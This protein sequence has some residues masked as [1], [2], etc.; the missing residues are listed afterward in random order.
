[1]KIIDKNKDYYDYLQ[2][3]WGQDPD[4][5]YAR[6]GS[7][8]FRPQDRPPFLSKDLP[9]GILCWQGEFIITCGAMVH[10]IYFE[11]RGKGLVLEEF[12]TYRV[13]RPE[14][15]AP[16]V[17]EW[18]VDEFETPGRK[19]YTASPWSKEGYCYICRGRVEGYPTKRGTRNPPSRKP[20]R[21]EKYQAR[22]DNPILSTIPLM[23]IPAETV[24]DEIQTYLRSIRDREIP[25][26]RTDVEKIE[27]AG[28][29]PKTSFRNM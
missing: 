6:Q 10:H 1:M 11:N 20:R 17:L 25:D 18:F 19:K 2:G 26:N 24:F 27:C 5:V 22:Y 8:K 16:L 15:A 3:V 7:V 4:A 21:F 23:V 28:F 14:G 29:D 13:V 12:F 9:D